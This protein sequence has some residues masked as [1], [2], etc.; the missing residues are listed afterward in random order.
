V[1]ATF[2]PSER[3]V[4]MVCAGRHVMCVSVASEPSPAS[5]FLTHALLRFPVRLW[6]FG[7]PTAPLEQ[8]C[9]RLIP[10]STVL[11]TLPSPPRRAHGSTLRQ[12]APHAGTLNILRCTSTA[13]YPPLPSPG[14]LVHVPDVYVYVLEA[15]QRRHIIAL[16]S[17]TRRQRLHTDRL[18]H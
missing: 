15:A 9:T 12:V 16:S 10:P 14:E 11:G 1:E 17:A 5:M 3:I 6:P 18:V 7:T 2:R 8:T 4:A 13:L